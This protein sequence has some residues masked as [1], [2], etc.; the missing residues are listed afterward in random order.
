[1][2]KTI[3]VLILTFLVT[4]MCVEQDSADDDIVIV[5]ADYSKYCNN[6]ADFTIVSEIGVYSDALLEHKL[7]LMD[8]EINGS[9]VSYQFEQSDGLE[10]IYVIPPIISKENK[11]EQLT[12][13]ISDG[14][15][16]GCEYFC[17]D[18]ISSGTNK[19]IETGE[20]SEQIVVHI[21][22]ETN[23]YPSRLILVSNGLY[24][25][26]ETVVSFL[27]NSKEISL[28]NFMCSYSV[29]DNETVIDDAL[30]DA[31]FKCSRLISFEQ[32]SKASFSSSHSIKINVVTTN[33]EEE[34][35]V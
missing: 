17:I 25:S 22:S 14:T 3:C 13:S 26:G 30:K 16:E 15:A 29:G 28:Q 19:D 31:Y 4:A 2:K 18:D 9:K 8:K 27:Q 21:S 35:P 12:I 20:V 32:A 1:M 11:I 23:Q 34:V 7:N 10:E 24:Y 33:I 6:I 5:T